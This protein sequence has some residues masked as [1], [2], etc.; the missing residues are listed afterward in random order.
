M[1]LGSNNI[2]SNNSKTSPTS[3]PNSKGAE[4][5]EDSKP[6]FSTKAHS[7]SNNHN[8]NNNNSNNFK[9]GA[10]FKAAVGLEARPSSRVEEISIHKRGVV[11]SRFKD[12][13]EVVEIILV[14]GPHPIPKLI[15]LYSYILSYSHTLIISY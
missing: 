14:G 15:L 12:V 4:A 11:G 8:S 6:A 2:Y 7:S 9:A 13:G 10:V 3:P 1:G 5:G